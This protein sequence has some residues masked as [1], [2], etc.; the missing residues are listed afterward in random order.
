MK[1]TMT[2]NEV[3]NELMQDEYAGQTYAGAHAI[4]EML[5]QFEDD[6]GYEITFDCV[7]IRCD[8][9][10]YESAAD[11]ANDYFASYKNMTDAIDLS[12]CEDDEEKE[13]A[14][15]EYLQENTMVLVFDGGLI[16]QAF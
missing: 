8:F 15:L 5:E 12:S 4:A 1:I 10:E 9:N 7:A 3:A 11:W 2:T 6:C 13:E 14:I 16:I